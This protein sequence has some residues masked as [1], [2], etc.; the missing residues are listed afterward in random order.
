VYQIFE[1]A[2]FNDC[3]NT[4]GVPIFFGMLAWPRPL[5]ILVLKVFGKLV[6]N[7]SCV[8]NLNLLALTVAE[9]S[10]GS[11]IFLDA[12]HAQTPANFGLKRCFLVS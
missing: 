8:P 9:I 6:P 10:R 12:L 11:H 4:Q 3:K 2:S 5:P 7:P 1:V